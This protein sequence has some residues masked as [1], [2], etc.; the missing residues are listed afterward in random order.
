M[1]LTVIVH[2]KKEGGYWNK[3]SSIP[4]CATQSETFDELLGNIYETLE[5]CLPSA[6]IPA[7]CQSRV[8]NSSTVRPAWRMMLRNVPFAS[9]VWWGTVSRRCG[10]L[11]CRRM[12]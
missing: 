10:G 4:G 8:I 11:D 6:L 7:T 9:S 3:G 12:R 5:G 1:N 2:E